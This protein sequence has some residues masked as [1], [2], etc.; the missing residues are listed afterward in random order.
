MATADHAARDSR[1]RAA[2][3]TCGCRLEGPGC[4]HPKAARRGNSPLQV[5]AATPWCCNHPPARGCQE[6]PGAPRL[7]VQPTPNPPLRGRGRAWRMTLAGK[8]PARATKAGTGRR[9]GSPLDAAASPAPRGGLGS[10]GRSRPPVS[11]AGA[12]LPACL[13]ASRASPVAPGR[14]SA[15]RRALPGAPP[16][17]PGSRRQHVRRLPTRPLPRRAPAGP[18]C[19]CAGPPPSPPP[20]GDAGVRDR[21]QALTRRL[22]SAVARGPPAPATG[23]GFGSDRRRVQGCHP[24]S[25]PPSLGPAVHPKPG[26]SNLFTLESPG[27]LG[28]CS[29]QASVGL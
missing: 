25:R 5:Q 29:S 28:Q 13:P 23:V 7:P 14:R 4:P 17:A 2:Q 20:R 12:R 22:S 19:T 11:T 24:T 21:T 27:G 16:P 10:A 9:T 15:G 26:L 8:L 18:P 3:F 6:L 1:A